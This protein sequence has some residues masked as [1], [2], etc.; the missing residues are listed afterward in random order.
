[1]S[2]NPD[3]TGHRVLRVYDRQ[4][5]L[6]STSENVPGLEHPLVWR[7]SG[8]LIVGTQR[9]GFEGGG[10]GKKGRHDVVFFERNGLRHGE[11]GLRVDELD[12][13]PVGDVG[14][15]WGYR[16]RELSWSSDSN[17]LG[18]WIERDK[19][20]VGARLTLLLFHVSV[21]KRSSSSSTLDHEQLSL[22]SGQSNRFVGRAHP[23][24]MFRYL[25]QEIPAPSSPSH[26]E[27]FTSVEW[28]PEQALCL[29]LTTSSTLCSTVRHRSDISAA[30]IIQ[31]TY[32]WE[33]FTS[34][35]LPPNDSGSVAVVDGCTSQAFECP[36]TIAHGS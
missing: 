29:I 11:F 34:P 5:S 6:Q 27:R 2:P 14:K 26:P 17:V 32:S 7:P 12:A 22:V 36:R 30:E 19:S 35:T 24:H 18:V 33:T 23:K 3:G 4:A 13:K 31:H 8:N 21:L 9:F 25:K 20:D 16:I 1:M 10:V 28:H 15:H